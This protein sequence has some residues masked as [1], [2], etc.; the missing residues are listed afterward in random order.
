M[1]VL[2]EDSPEAQPLKEALKKAQDQYRVLLVGEKTRLNI[3]IHPKI[4]GE[5]REGGSRVGSRKDS[6]ATSIGEFGTIA[7]QKHPT[8]CRSPR[9]TAAF[10]RHRWT[11]RTQRRRSGD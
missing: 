5:D 2:R 4:S 9:T 3:E 8:V 10:R 1:K 6:L 11:S 7:G